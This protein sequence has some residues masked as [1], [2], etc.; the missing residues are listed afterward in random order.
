M[1]FFDNIK[2]KL[3]YQY[4][5]TCLHITSMSFQQST[6]TKLQVTAYQRTIIIKEEE[7]YPDYKVSK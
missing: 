5:V 1:F 4:S 6:F 3:S 2:Y 7:D